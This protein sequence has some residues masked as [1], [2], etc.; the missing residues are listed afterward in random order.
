MNIIKNITSI[1]TCN[2]T[3]NLVEY[4]NINSFDSFTPV[5]KSNKTKLITNEIIKL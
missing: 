4:S 1:I 2:P 3:K 5:K